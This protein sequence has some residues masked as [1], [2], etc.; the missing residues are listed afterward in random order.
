LIA[1]FR[2][3]QAGS[4]GQAGAGRY[5][6]IMQLRLLAPLFACAAP[7][8]VACGGPDD[9][10]TPGP[11]TTSGGEPEPV[12]LSLSLTWSAC[13][14]FTEVGAP[15]VAAECAEVDVPLRWDDPKGRSISLFVKRLPAAGARR[16]SLWVLD[17]GPGGGGV[18]LEGVAHAIAAQ[19]DGLDVYIPHHRGTGRSSKLSCAGDQP[20]SEGGIEITQ[21]E[22]P[23]CIDALVAAY[24]EG[25]AGFSTTEAARDLGALVAAEAQEGDQVFVMGQSYGTYLANRYLKLHPDQA[26]GVILDSIC[27]PDAC[28]LD[29]FDV[30]YDQVA[31]D[32]LALCGAD[33]VCSSHVGA[34]PG[35]RLAA[36]YTSLEA[37]H[38]PELGALG[39]DRRALRTVL[40]VMLNDWNARL[41]I[42]AVIARAERCD[43]ADVAAMEHLV[44]ALFGAPGDP[45]S[46]F[47]EAWSFPLQN[48]IVFSEMWSDPPPAPEAIVAA[49]D[50]TRI[51]QGV[52]II[53]A[54]VFP[55]WPRYERD[56][57]VGAWGDN[58]LPMLMMNGDLDPATPLSIAEAAGAHF[59][60]ERQVFVA[61]PRSPHGVLGGSPINPMGETCGMQLVLD[62]VADPTAPLDTSCKD[63]VL[64]LNFGGASWLSQAL[65][66]TGDFYALP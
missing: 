45:P 9:P 48:N 26:T 30:L 15:K 29:Q 6:S 54:A 46:A 47:L 31:A 5:G 1:A 37:G 65:F 36:L 55:A 60:G 53:D 40:G 56:E 57:L 32:F 21:A 33:P 52:S 10:V 62:F 28:H 22:W 17:G 63:Q 19:D 13:D 41:A 8:L 12:A 38:C 64:P 4:V 20:G 23:A 11:G 59:T 58:D 43:P 25:L 14:L 61:L 51:A 42:P 16:G 24:G 49:A 50:A 34:D 35:A 66:G 2:I 39:L 44:G 3:F 18:G 27:P 7:L